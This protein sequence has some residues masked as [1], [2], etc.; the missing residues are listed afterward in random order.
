MNR[1]NQLQSLRPSILFEKQAETTLEKF[2]NDT[3]RPILKLQNDL[4]IQVFTKYCQQRK[5]L[6]FKLSDKDKL[7]YID[8]N[9]RK[10]MK[11]KHYLEG[12][13]TGHFTLDEYQ[14]FLNHEEEL[15][16][17]MIHLLIQRLQSQLLLLTM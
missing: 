3:L 10:D 11:F 16:K 4:L 15:T 9:I 1:D 5:G 13:I 14:L 17:R 8:Q 2:Q 7:I 12:I 6:F